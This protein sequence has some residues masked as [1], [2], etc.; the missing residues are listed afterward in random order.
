MTIKKRILLAILLELGAYGIG[1]LRFGTAEKEMVRGDIPWVILCM[2]LGMTGTVVL[3]SAI[4]KSARNVKWLQT[5]KTQPS[6]SLFWVFWLVMCISDI[7]R[8]I[9]EYNM[10][11]VE[12]IETWSRISFLYVGFGLVLFFIIAAVRSRSVGWV[13]ALSIFSIDKNSDER[14]REIQYQAT[15]ITYTILLIVIMSVGLQLG[16]RPPTYQG[17]YFT[18][19]TTIFF[20]ATALRGFISWFLARR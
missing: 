6:F 2:V 17:A 18:L 12:G 3:L 5:Q 19:G 10:P 7:Q 1:F 11:K 9:Q 20:G 14:E 16:V 15:A 4:Y 8:L 13:K